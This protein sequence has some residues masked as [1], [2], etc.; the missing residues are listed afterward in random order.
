MKCQ[1]VGLSRCRYDRQHGT[2]W[3]LFWIAA[4][5]IH[6]GRRFGLWF[7]SVRGLLVK[8]AGGHRLQYWGRRLLKIVISG[9]IVVGLFEVCAVRRRMLSINMLL[10]RGYPLDLQKSP[11]PS[12]LQRPDGG[13]L[14]VLVA[15]R[16]YLLRVERFLEFRLDEK[17]R[18]QESIRKE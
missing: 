14:R 5:E 11:Q 3:M 17:R 12:Y 6:A 16:V 1:L 4:V 2:F 9:Q 10:E 7:P 15:D 13:R 18:W 8:S